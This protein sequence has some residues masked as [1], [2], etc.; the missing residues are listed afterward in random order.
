MTG[1]LEATGK[2]VSSILPT[3]NLVGL[4]VARTVADSC[5]FSN[6]QIYFY[7]IVTSRGCFSPKEGKTADLAGKN[8]YGGGQNF[9]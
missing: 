4:Q 6:F 3:N 8:E 1:T 2:N 9:V 5:C 7:I